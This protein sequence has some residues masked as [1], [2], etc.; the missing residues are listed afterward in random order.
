MGG[1]RIQTLV[2][3]TSQ[4]FLNIFSMAFHWEGEKSSNFTCLMFLCPEWA[5]CFDLYLN[6]LYVFFYGL[7]I[8]FLFH[9]VSY[10]TFGEGVFC[11]IF[12]AWLL[13]SNFD[14]FGCYLRNFF[15]CGGLHG[16]II[17]YVKKGRD[18]SFF[19]GSRLIFFPHKRNRRKKLLL[20]LLTQ[21]FR[22]KTFCWL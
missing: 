2:L 13:Q 20:G 8:S 4:V 18:V 10:I 9:K 5:L 7:L 14:F 16:R 22:V 1:F 17:F 3:T 6:E 15:A 19:L 11:L 21:S 12:H